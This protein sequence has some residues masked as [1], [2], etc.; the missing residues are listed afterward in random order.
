MSAGRRDSIS[1]GVGQTTALSAGLSSSAIPPHSVWHPVTCHG[2][3]IVPEHFYSH[4]NVNSVAKGGEFLN[5][6][7]EAI[8]VGRHNPK[9]EECHTSAE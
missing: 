3:V 8:D 7:P 9:A 4:H 2:S 6:Y 1:S 5:I